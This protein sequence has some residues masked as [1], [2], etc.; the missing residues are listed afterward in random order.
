MDVKFIN[1]YNEYID[2]E[3]GVKTS[4][5]ELKAQGYKIPEAFFWGSENA[6][7]SSG[8][9]ILD[10]II[11]GYWI[12]KYQLSEVTEYIVDY[13]Y[14]VN[15]TNVELT[16]ITINSDEE[17]TKCTYAING[18]IKAEL[19]DQSNGYT[20]TDVSEGKQ[21]INV[22]ALNENGEIIGSYTVT[23]ELEEPARPDTSSFDQD[24]T[25]YVWWDESGNEHNET[26]ISMEP[27]EKWY[28]YSNNIWANIVTRNNGLE[29]YFVWIPRYEYRL[30]TLKERAEIKFIGTD[31][32]NENC[33]PSYQVP[34][35]F[36]W[37]N[38]SNGIEEEGE[39]IPGYWITKYQLEE[40]S[41]ELRI[42]AN[43]QP[44]N[45]QIQIADI[46]GSLIDIAK[47]DG[48]QIKFEYYLD[49]TLMKDAIGQS[50]TENY[51]YKNLNEGTEYTI[52]I[53]L[54]NKVTNEYIGAITK[55]INTLT[56][57]EIETNSL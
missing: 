46:T 20:F 24:T 21:I 54:R 56:T 23:I 19:T 30:N 36:W 41:N 53:I 49:G 37:D 8:K 27:P 52:N 1:V 57:S 22:T 5:Q 43:M 15:M 17:V 33:T 12:S 26:P 50:E 35:A 2:G 28:K 18:E 29:T 25:F 31:I 48:T 13:N 32:T 47:E 55:K 45:N 40:V 39:Q 42:D 4:W 38:N 10:T 16:N 51:I 9:G 34:E 11:P 6:M 44:S 14:A 3:T 7:Y